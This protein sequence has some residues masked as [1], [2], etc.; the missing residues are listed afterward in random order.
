[1]R[2][3]YHYLSSVMSMPSSQFHALCK[4]KKRSSSSMSYLLLA[5]GRMLASFMICRYA[6][7]IIVLFSFGVPHFIRCSGFRYPG[8]KTCG[9]LG[10]EYLSL[11]IEHPS[12]KGSTLTQVG[13]LSAGP[14]FS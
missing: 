2:A 11:K 1:M 10:A 14:L 3:G 13:Q 6:A 8:G 5:V 9:F 4:R 12:E 7:V